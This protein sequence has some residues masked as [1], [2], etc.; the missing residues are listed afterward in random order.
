[1]DHP[2]RTIRRLVDES[3]HAMSRV[4]TTMYSHTGHPSIPP[5]RLIRAL[6][7]QVLYSIRSE[8]QLVEQFDYNLLLGWA[9]TRRRGTP[10]ASP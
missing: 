2:L 7:R 9:W 4:L 8:R 5:E 1:L 3:L 6:L 10:S